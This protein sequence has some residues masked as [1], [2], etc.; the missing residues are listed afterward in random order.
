MKTRKK[1][2]LVIILLIIILL[3][4]F[5]WIRNK[6]SRDFPEIQS[7]G[8]LNIVTEYNSVDY[9]VSGDS[10]AGFQYELCKY[11]EKCSGLT[12]H[13]YLENNLDI[14]INKL[15][16][17]AY[18]IIAR[19]IPVTNDNKAFLSFTVPIAQNKQILLQRKETPGDSVP[20]I[21]NQI[22]LANKTIYIPQHSPS[23][24]RLRNLSEEIAEPIYIKEISDYTAEELIYMV[25]YKEIDYAVID[26]EL[27][28]KN[29]ANFPEIDIDTDI[30][31]TQNQ[32]WAVRKTSPALLDSL[33]SWIQRKGAPGT[34]YLINDK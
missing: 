2:I 3:T 30:S 29:S 17:N 18:D 12:V 13:I 8:V 34:L 14:C 28:L 33:N 5:L 22:D 31:F 19:N 20:L 15:E 27:A 26:K 24:L 23:I 9:Y 11:I 25:A 6:S 4:I 10:I 32:A 1:N 7:D 16:D 21:R